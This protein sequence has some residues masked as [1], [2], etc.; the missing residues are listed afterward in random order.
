[1]DMVEGTMRWKVASIDNSPGSS[2]V[3]VR[4]EFIGLLT[5]RRSDTP[6][7]RDSTWIPSDVTYGA[8]SEDANHSVTVTT[9]ADGQYAHYGGKPVTF[10]RFPANAVDDTL[11]VTGADGSGGF[12]TT[13]KAKKDF[14]LVYFYY[15]VGPGMTSY[16]T[17]M[18]RR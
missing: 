3:T 1:M 13:V 18:K 17:T 10:Q 15:W 2:Q 14:G 9:E 11:Q 12:G 7:V 6:Y 16:R 4:Q 5:K 8:I